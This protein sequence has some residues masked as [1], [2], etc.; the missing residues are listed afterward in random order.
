MEQETKTYRMFTSHQQRFPIEKYAL[1][2]ES[3]PELGGK[4][5][6]WYTFYQPATPG[7]RE[8]VDMAVMPS[9]PK[10]RVLAYLTEM[11]NQQVRTSVYSY[12]CD[13]EDEVQRYRGLLETRRRGGGG[14]ETVGFGGTV[15][16]RALGAALAADSG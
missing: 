14:F 11:A 1:L 15:L 12:D 2:T 8:L 10:Q 3:A 4:L 6:E 7:E 16:D 9:V 13:R 5:D